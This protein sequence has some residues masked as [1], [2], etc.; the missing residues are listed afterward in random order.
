MIKNI[1]ISIVIFFLF[2]NCNQSDANNKKKETGNISS[3]ELDI[4]FTRLSLDSSF[5][6]NYIQKH[7]ISA[8]AAKK[9]RDFYSN[10]DFQYAW[11]TE[12]GL[13]EHTLAFWNLHEQYV[14]LG[15]DSSL[16]DQ[17]LH[18]RM[19]DLLED[20]IASPSPEYISETE[21]LLTEH[22]FDF[23]RYAYTGKIDPE[24]M[25]WHIPR[26]K[27][28]AVKLLDS[29]TKTKGSIENWEPV[30]ESYT[31]LQNQLTRLYDIEKAG[32]WKNIKAGEKTVI[33]KGDSAA[34]VADIKNN[35]Y[36][37]GDF[38]STD[39]SPKYTA[40][41]Y[42][43]VIEFQRRHG[44]EEDGVIGPAVMREI[45]VPIEKRIEQVLINMERMR[46]LQMNKEGKRIVVNVPEY[47]VHIYNNEK[48]VFDM[49]IVVGKAATKTVIFSDEVKHVVFAP[50][51]N[52]PRS[53]IR[54][55]ILPAMRKNSNYLARNNME[56]TG[57]S[58][59]LPVIR[60][61]PGPNNALGRVKFLFPNRYSIYLHDTPAKTLFKRTKRTF[62]HGC[63]RVEK[64]LELAAFLLQE[65][66]Q[67]DR[68]KISTAM[69]STREKWV[70]LDKPVPVY[71]TYFTS[72]V[73]KNGKLNFREDIYG[74]DDRLAKRLFQHENH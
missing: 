39:R 28:D 32:N 9:I 41:L 67:W 66:P 43:A 19:T 5:I 70:N 7:Q 21:V 68:Q 59:G 23:S 50:Y 62:S 26:R 63:I 27:I 6:E 60:Q 42:N 37:A 51:W 1:S 73:D 16:F 61:K 29:L 11:F 18:K 8:D 40:E 2:V 24:K 13:A 65:S 22:F 54:N 31:L 30:N 20:E 38:N 45:D 10:R 57:Y 12:D 35:F 17:D 48:E 49:A 64:P 74:H 55:E 14:N 71:I 52:I 69:Q 3:A 72:W 36:L 15:Q 56:Q 47:R 53:I 34:V 25:Q 44:L 46:W 4:Q 33:R 58:N